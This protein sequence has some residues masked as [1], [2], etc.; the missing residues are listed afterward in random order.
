M[1]G[2]IGDGEGAEQQPVPP[3]HKTPASPMAPQQPA[4]P[5]VDAEACK[6][7]GNKFYKAQQYDKAV[8]EYTKGECVTFPREDR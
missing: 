7:Q 5:A 8:E 6:A 4:K 2:M 3:P 1:V